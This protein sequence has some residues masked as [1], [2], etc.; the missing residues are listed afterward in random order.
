M[1]KSKVT[2]FHSLCGFLPSSIKLVW[3]R[4]KMLKSG[5]ISI[6]KALSLISDAAQSRRL[7]PLWGAFFLLTRLVNMNNGVRSVYHGI[8]NSCRPLSMVMRYNIN[9][10]RVIRNNIA[11]SGCQ[12]SYF[13]CIM[14]YLSGISWPFLVPTYPRVLPILS[15]LSLVKPLNPRL[16]LVRLSKAGM[17]LSALTSSPISRSP[18]IKGYFLTYTAVTPGLFQ[19]TAIRIDEAYPKIAALDPF[20]RRFRFYFPGHWEYW[21]LTVRII[22]PGSQAGREHESSPA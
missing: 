20:Q 19:Q 5:Q 14:D 3:W 8:S 4:F 2:S 18:I 15:K 16:S 6:S 21:V 1:A 22:R 12:M 9:S 10:V 11:H 7:R 13:C 17:T